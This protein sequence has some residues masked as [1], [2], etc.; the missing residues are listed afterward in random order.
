MEENSY[1][2]EKEYVYM[3]NQTCLMYPITYQNTNNNQVLKLYSKLLRKICLLV[4]IY[5]T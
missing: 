1:F 3:S 5:I 2:T 4:K